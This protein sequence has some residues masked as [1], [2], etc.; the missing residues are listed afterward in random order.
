MKA[1]KL[2][3]FHSS[4]S[5]VAASVLALTSHFASGDTETF[6]T[7]GTF[8]WVCPR[9]GREERITILAPTPPKTVLAAA[10][11]LMPDGPRFL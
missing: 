2:S 9:V 6:N 3:Y 11:E 1:S 8:N 4:L 7:A 5:V 10:A